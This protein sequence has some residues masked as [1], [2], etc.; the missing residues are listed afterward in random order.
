ME[1]DKRDKKLVLG[2]VFLN[3]YKTAEDIA[4]MLGDCRDKDE[5]KEESKSPISYLFELGEDIGM[6]LKYIQEEVR[7]LR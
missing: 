6:T 7:R 2:E 1:E 3:I 4:R 5:K